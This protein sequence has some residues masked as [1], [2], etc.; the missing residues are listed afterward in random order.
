MSKRS[1]SDWIADVL[2]LKDIPFMGVPDYMYNINYWLGA[3]S[4]SALFW[5]AITGLLLLLY[6]QPSNAYAST[7]AIISSVPFGSILLSS[8][9]YGAYVMIMATYIHGLY[10]FFKGGYKKPRGLQWVLGVLLFALTL[11]AA[12]LGYSLTGDVLSTDAVDVGRGIMGALG[13]S[14]LAPIAFGNGTQLD[15]FTRLLG[16]HIIIVAVIA[17]FFVLHFYLAEQNGFMPRHSEVKGMAPAV[18]KK[19][20]PRIK[21]WWPRNFIFMIGIVLLTWG[22]ILAVPSALAIPSVLQHVPILFS[23]YPGPSPTSPAAASVP[24]YP[25]WFFLAIYKAMDMPFGLAADATLG[26]LIPIIILL[27]IPLLDRGP[28]LRVS[29][30]PFVVGLMITGVTWLIELS[31]WGA[32]QPGVPAQIQYVGLVM[33]PPLVI[34]FAGSYAA[35]FFALRGSRPK[36]P[37]SARVLERGAAT[38]LSAVTAVLAIV[39]SLLSFTLNPISQGPY[40]GLLWGAALI[41]LASSFFTYFYSEYLVGSK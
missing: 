40:I 5:Q 4:A 7:E 35:H 27:I 39:A 30:R 16:L 29:D 34:S 31:V 24:P 20:D 10:V 19:D 2:H 33:L 23:P 8:H 15:L 12:F 32:L 38:A 37:K 22:V 9:L 36:G 41:S 6:Y 28:S 18:L 21:P 3:I 26:S 13:L 1:L 11:G 17:L 14:S 25:P